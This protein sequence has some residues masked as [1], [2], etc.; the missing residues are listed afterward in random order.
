VKPVEQA[1]LMDGAS[2]AEKSGR[3]EAEPER[4]NLPRKESKSKRPPLILATYRMPQN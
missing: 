4:E 1:E 2:R 3:I